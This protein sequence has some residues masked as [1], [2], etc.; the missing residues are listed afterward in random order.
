MAISVPDA[1]R[2]YPFIA[3]SSELKAYYQDRFMSDIKRSRPA[4]VVDAC[5]PGSFRFLDRSFS[6]E[7]FASFWSFLGDHY[8]LVLDTSNEDVDG[9]RVWRLR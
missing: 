1:E 7:S 6:P 2:A 8:V 3:V 9:M 4:F 5:Y